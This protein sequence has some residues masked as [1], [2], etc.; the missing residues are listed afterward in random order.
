MALPRF[1]LSV[2]ALQHRI[3]ENLCFWEKCL[4]FKNAQIY[5]KINAFSTYILKNE[6]PKNQIWEM[7]F[8]FGN[9]FFVF[10]DVFGKRDK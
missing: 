8:A 10:G 3:F 7:F 1:I 9:L 2:V 6:F 5:S 4:S